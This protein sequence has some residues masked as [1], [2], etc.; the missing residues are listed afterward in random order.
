MVWK[1]TYTRFLAALN[2]SLQGT[3]QEH[4][5]RREMTEFLLWLSLRFCRSSSS[6][7][8][9]R[10]RDREPGEDSTG[11]ES[12][13]SSWSL[14]DILTPHHCLLVS[15]QW[16]SWVI[17]SFRW[18]KPSK[19]IEINPA[20]PNPA[21]NHVPKCHFYTFKSLQEW[22]L[23]HVPGQLCHCWTALLVKNFFW[24]FNLDLPWCNFSLFSLV[25]SSYQ[26]LTEFL[27]RSP[28]NLGQDTISCRREITLI[29]RSG[30]RLHLKSH[31][32]FKL[33]G[34]FSYISPI[35]MLKQKKSKNLLKENILIS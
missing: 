23:H 11:R 32:Y 21:L 13:V 6:Q 20:L 5:K 15:L 34:L 31:C 19:T 14:W 4:G 25:L 10:F 30:H 28:Q 18:K 27:Q 8:L 7:N 3:V 26:L 17:E 1:L 24:I 29:F 22:G 2:F 33:W 9:V 16:F 12:L 35:K